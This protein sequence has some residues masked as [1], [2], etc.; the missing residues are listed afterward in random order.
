MDSVAFEVFGQPIA[1]YGIIISFG[2]LVAIGLTYIIAKKEGLDFEIII[3]G[4]LWA[5]PIAIIC[6]RLYYVAFEWQ[7]YKTFM[8][9]INIRGGGLAIHGGLIGGILTA[10]VVTKIKKVNFLQYI[11]IVMPGVILA[12][13][14]GRW[15]NFMNQEAHGDVVSA[16][17]ISKFPQ[18]IQ[19][20]MHINGQYY[21][22]TFLYESIWN[23][24][25]CGLL[26]Y[27]LSKKKENQNG[28]VLGS[29]M[30]LYSVGRFF[31]EGL[32]TDSLMFFG[33]R[34]A[35]IVSLIGIVAGI[36][37]IIMAIKRGKK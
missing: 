7:N 33:L 13:A 16:E 34:I 19:N 2:V 37:F 23:V 15:G 14:I 32:R 30:A 4:F 20:G 5:F 8:D 9:V 35:Q 10:L 22:P 12:Q 3:D 6:A 31:I 36:G 11:D 21:H 26:I 24:V 1:W 17:F 25:V 27:I 18:F 28:I 29:Y